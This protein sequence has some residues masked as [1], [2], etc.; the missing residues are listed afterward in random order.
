[1]CVHCMC[2]HL[3]WV[4]LVKLMVQS[5]LLK[6]CVVCSG[7]RVLYRHT[8]VRQNHQSNRTCSLE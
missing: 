5:Y 6:I 8:N 2:F 1:M 4:K 7:E 3:K